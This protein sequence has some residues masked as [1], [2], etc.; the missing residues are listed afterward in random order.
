M[1][2]LWNAS[3]DRQRQHLLQLQSWGTSGTIFRVE[4][5]GGQARHY[6]VFESAG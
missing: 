5:D 2:P 4:L 1:H 6:I 3:T